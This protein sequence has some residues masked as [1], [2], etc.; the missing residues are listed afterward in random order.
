MNRILAVALVACAVLSGEAAAQQST[1]AQSDPATM[2]RQQLRGEVSRLRAVVQGRAV[3]PQRPPG[4]TGAEYRQ[5]DFWLGQ[6]DVS[7]TGSA[8]VIVAESSITATDQGCVIIEEWRPFGGAHGHSI[9]IYDATEHR[10]RQT[11][12]DA[13]GR[14]T[15]YGGTLDPNGV[16]RFDNL[17]P[18]DNEPPPGRR[19][20]NYQRIDA[21]TVRQW[22]ELFDA[23]TQAWT[24]EWDFTYRRRAG[25]S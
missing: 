11:W 17:S 8:D 21:D 5:F 1:Q 7:P 18:P 14:R 9:N 3:Q 2:T 13:T 22:G 15:E 10:W 20:M 4:C 16:L 19:R 12:A 24:I 25:G 23:H 6:W